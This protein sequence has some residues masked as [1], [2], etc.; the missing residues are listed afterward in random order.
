ML[1]FCDVW[2]VY[3]KNKV[4]IAALKGV[5]LEIGRGEFAALLGES[6]SGKSTILNIAGCL[7]KPSSGGVLV[8]GED[9]CRADEGNL[10]RLRNNAI[11]FIF[12]SFYLQH[13][14]TA[15]ENIM[16]PMIIAGMAIRERK[17]R[18]FELLERMGLS[19]RAMHRPGELSGGQ[20]Q[21]VCIARALAN[22]PALILADEPTGNL[23]LNTGNSVVEL[24]HSLAIGGITVLMVTHNPTHAGMADRILSIKNGS[25]IR[26]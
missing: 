16:L 17:P 7:D 5:S 8:N 2:K 14:L 26:A 1:K 12:Q 15:L 22:N 4:E 19:D 24:L 21:R 6:G 11:G 20:R 23:D 3:K 10:A 18:A 9:I 25:L 13:H